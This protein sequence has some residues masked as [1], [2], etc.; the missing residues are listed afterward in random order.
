MTDAPVPYIIP[1]REVVSSNLET[2]AYDG[3]HLVVTFKNGARWQYRDVP[4]DIVDAMLHAESIGRYFGQNIRSQYHARDLGGMA[5]ARPSLTQAAVLEW[6]GR[7]FGEAC[8][9]DHAERGGRMLEEA[10]ELAQACGVD[11]EAAT[12]LVD[13]IYRRPVCLPSQEVGGLMITIYALAEMLGIDMNN[14]AAA[15]WQRIC[16]MP[17]DY[18]DKKHAEKH[19]AGI[20]IAPP[21]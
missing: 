7:S 15:E 8:T 12:R 18:W 16:E 13:H 3:M 21:K 19:A 5:G 6:V 10:I 1:P 9:T 17:A 4:A 11:H 20:A 14:V 2:I